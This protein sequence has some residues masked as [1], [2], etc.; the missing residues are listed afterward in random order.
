[1]VKWAVCTK[2]LKLQ[3]DMEG[4]DFL[5]PPFF[6]PLQYSQSSS[7]PLAVS[8]F[9]ARY[10]PMLPPARDCHKIKEVNPNLDY[11]SV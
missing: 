4:K 10:D 11:E 5:C 3:V 7:Q 9:V 6:Y 8:A 1:M 2:R